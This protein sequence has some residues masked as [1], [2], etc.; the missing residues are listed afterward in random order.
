[1]K[2]QA[3]NKPPADSSRRSHPL[4]AASTP[5][6]TPPVTIAAPIAPPPT[7]VGLE[8]KQEPVDTIQNIQVLPVTVKAVDVPEKD[9]IFTI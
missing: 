9:R 3:P 1:M 6:V 5:D 8:K 2:K 4:S 7:E